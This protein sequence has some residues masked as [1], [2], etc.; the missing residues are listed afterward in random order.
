MDPELDIAVLQVEN[1]MTFT[2]LPFGNSDEIAPGMIVLACGNP[3]GLMPVCCWQN[4]S[5]L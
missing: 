4:A 2:P 3:Y 5:I 1:P